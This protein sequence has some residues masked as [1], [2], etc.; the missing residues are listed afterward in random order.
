MVE[1]AT[2][3]EMSVTPPTLG[4]GSGIGHGRL[5]TRVSLRWTDGKIRSGGA[6][7]QGWGGQRTKTY[8]SL[9]ML[10]SAD[11]TRPRVTGVVVCR[12]WLK[13]EWRFI[14]CWQS[15]ISGIIKYCAPTEVVVASQAALDLL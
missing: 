3:H 4:D 6:I 14:A 12:L 5:F 13:S 10:I 1:D 11:T 8:L 7:G 9:C 15:N 2:R